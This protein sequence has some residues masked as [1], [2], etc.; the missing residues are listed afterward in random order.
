MYR[1][2]RLVPQLIYGRGSINQLGDI[3]STQRTD[4]GSPVVFL[5]DAVHEKREFLQKLPLRP[6]D[7]VILV[8]VGAEPKTHYVDELTER[9]KAF[10]NRQ[11]DAIVGI[12]G[13]ST[14]DLA[15]AVSIMLTNPGSAADYQGWDLVKYP[16]IY[17]RNSHV[18]RKRGGGFAHGRPHGTGQETGYQFR[19]HP[20]R[21]DRHGSQSHRQRATE[22]TVLYGDGLLYS[23]M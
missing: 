18:G 7:L 5:I 12:G 17:H 6:N 4:A 1:N 15:K 2:L 19:L 9:V 3:L 22:P 23:L 16:A 14:M 11:P 20:L 13:G 21:S 10:S 8:D